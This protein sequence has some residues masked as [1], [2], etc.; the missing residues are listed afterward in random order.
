MRLGIVQDFTTA[1]D[2]EDDRYIMLADLEHLLERDDFEVAWHGDESQMR[3]IPENIDMLLVDYGGL[4]SSYGDGIYRY[5]RAVREWADAHPGK[6][7]LLTTAFT[8]ACYKAV[9]EGDFEQDNVF[10]RY[11]SAWDFEGEPDLGQR[12]AAWLSG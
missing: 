9:F 11:R 7:V 6:P 2:N 1:K 8:V 5:G 10:Y 3:A 4:H 12:L